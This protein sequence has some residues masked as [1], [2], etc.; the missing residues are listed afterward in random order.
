MVNGR[1]WFACSLWLAAAC[2][3]EIEGRPSLVQRE[4]VLALRSSPAEGKPQAQLTYDS[5]FVSADGTLDGSDLDWALCHERKPLTQAGTIAQ[6][7][8]VPEGS[9]LEALGVGA[10]VPGSVIKDGCSLFGPTPPTPKP[11]EP[12]V[13]PVDPDTTGGYYQTVRVLSR[14]AGDEYSVG[15]T[16]LA[17]GLG[18]ATQEQSAEFTKRYR[19]NENPALDSLVLHHEDG[20][21]ETLSTAD[22]GQ[23]AQLI[24]GERVQLEAAWQDCPVPDVCGDGICGIDEDSSPASC[25]DDCKTPHGCSGAEQYVYFNPQDRQLSD[26]REAIRVSWF[27][28]AGR[29]DHERTG[30]SENEAQNATDNPWT[31]PDA[32]VDVWLWVVI[33]DDRG[34]TGWGSYRL[35]VQ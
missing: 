11:G 29:F 33:R 13:R 31:A 5:L 6:N 8:L 23:I 1:L 17:C 21:H 19:P 30:I 22:S 7:C 16:R 18:G 20:R 3:P 15:V 4:R 35:H 25:P 9:A 28:S 2:R 26:R 32:S 27:A 10:S 14:A 34:G 12:S 24:A